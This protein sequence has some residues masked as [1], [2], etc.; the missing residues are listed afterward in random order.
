MLL[1]L[2]RD[3][4]TQIFRPTMAIA[5]KVCLTFYR[6]VSLHNTVPPIFIANTFNPT[7]RMRLIF[8]VV[9][10]LSRFSYHVVQA[11]TPSRDTVR[12]SAN[13]E[14]VTLEVALEELSS[15]SGVPIT[16]SRSFLPNTPIT[17]QISQRSVSQTLEKLL[18]GTSLTFRWVGNELLV[19]PR[20]QKSSPQKIT[21]NGIV[22]DATTH[23]EL[24]GASVFYQKQNE[25]KPHGS[26]TNLNGFFATQLSKGNYTIWVKYLGYESQRHMW[27]LEKDTSVTIA[28]QP[29]PFQLSEVTVSENRDSLTQLAFLSN[30]VNLLQL[31]T[32]MIENVPAFLGEADVVR[33]LQ[34]LPSVQAIPEGS[35]GLFVRGGNEGQNLVLLDG[36]PIYNPNHMFGLFSIFNTDVVKHVDLYNEAFP[37]RFGG[38]IASVV[39]VHTKDGNRTQSEL[40]GS[41]GSIA[42]HLTYEAPWAKGKGTFWVGGRFTYIDLLMQLFS[43]QLPTDDRFYFYDINLKATWRDAKK[44]KF[45]F[46]AYIGRDNSGLGSTSTYS[47]GNQAYSLRW[48]KP[49]GNR[50][51]SESTLFYSNFDNTTEVSLVETQGYRQAY[52]LWD[53]GFRQYINYYHNDN[54]SLEFGVEAIQHEYNLGT[55]EPLDSLSIV[56]PESV[57]PTYVWE[58][59]AFAELE[60][61]LFE[62]FRVRAGIRYSRF[63]HIGPGS[64]YVY[65][66]HPVVSPSTNNN[67]IIGQEFYDSDEFYD[68]Q[69]GVEPRLSMSYRLSMPSS[70]K[71][72]YTRMFQYLHLL[73]NQGTVPPLALWFPSNRHMPAQYADLFSLGYFHQKAEGKY[74]FS[75]Q[76]YY[77][78]TRNQLDFKPSASIF[79]NDHIETEVLNGRNRAFGA[80]FLLSKD[81]GK[82]KG[83][84]S[85][86]F[87]RSLQEIDGINQGEA[88][89]SSFDRQHNIAVTMSHPLGKRW[90]FSANWLFA[91]GVAFSFPAG[92]YEKDGILLPYYTARNSFRLPNTHRLDLSF[93]LRPKNT[94]PSAKTG[95]LNLSLFNF[96]GRENPYSYVFRQSADD[97]S[98]TEVIKLFLFTVLPAVSYKFR[99]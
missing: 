79:L 34:L 12:I 44:G 54:I 20:T 39:E 78:I 76:G 1:L 22:K 56:V 73:S 8:F 28:L 14:A 46:S 83:S 51:F 57:S 23:E 9:I 68:T 71:L 6:L 96:Y 30:T 59:A 50:W 38:R 77:R 62:R 92:R 16:Y 41:V 19:V 29:T 72:T 93:T 63:D 87:S 53:L 58:S 33:S 15:Q 10:L 70:L 88:Y 40:A 48:S 84:L 82:L 49:I 85:Y 43:F 37:A 2:L 42:S 52:D 91:S 18:E 99:I 66:V 97:P 7:E 80:E 69:S 4:I 11:Q 95:E 94:N 17:L 55:I 36:A 25:A 67:N 24:I 21:L 3:F 86:T 47:W 74:R 27:H 60:Y 90:R 31:K 75:V 32:E 35:S 65:N 64:Q 89:P 26:T 13:W 5:Q 45:A 81:K 61:A 98:R